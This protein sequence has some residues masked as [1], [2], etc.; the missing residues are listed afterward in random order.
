MASSLHREQPL[1]NSTQNDDDDAVVVVA[2]FLLYLF[3]FFHCNKYA[4][5][6]ENFH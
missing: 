5:K 2:C 1:K 4:M 6:N 3:G